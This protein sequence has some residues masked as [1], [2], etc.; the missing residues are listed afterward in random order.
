MTGAGIRNTKTC[1]KYTL[2]ISVVFLWQ[3]LLL[4]GLKISNIFII[5][6]Q[7]LAVN[8]LNKKK[9]SLEDIEKGWII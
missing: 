4:P 9:L 5:S 7:N 8:N 3:I 1:P 2:T 6:D